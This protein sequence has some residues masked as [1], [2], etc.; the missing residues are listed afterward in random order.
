MNQTGVHP[1]CTTK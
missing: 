1:A